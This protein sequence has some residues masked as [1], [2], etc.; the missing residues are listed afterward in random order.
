MKP[1]CSSTLSGLS[2]QD[3]FVFI[4]GEMT[5]AKDM[6]DKRRNGIAVNELKQE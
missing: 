2:F 5:T 3:F 6:K 1:A 4:K